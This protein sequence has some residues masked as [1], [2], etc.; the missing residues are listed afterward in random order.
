MTKSRRD[1]LQGILVSLPTF[2]DKNFNLRLDRS[3]KHIRWLIDQGIVEGTGVLMIAGGLGEAG[4]A[5]VSG[6][7]RG[8]DAAAHQASL[9]TG[10]AAAM[11]GGVDVVYPKENSALYDS[12]IEQGAALSEMPIGTP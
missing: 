7:A 11:A 1:R 8:I 6:L 3:K 9:A 2:N 5:V 4:M 12:I 10:T